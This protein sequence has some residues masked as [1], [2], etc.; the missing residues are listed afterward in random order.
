MKQP[1]AV[2]GDGSP[3]WLTVLPPMTCFDSSAIQSQYCGLTP[4]SSAAMYLPAK[5]STKRPIARASASV[6]WWLE[7]GMMMT[8]FAPPIARPEAAAL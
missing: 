3:P 6:G 7:F 4:T 1:S 5:V 2:Y 8:L